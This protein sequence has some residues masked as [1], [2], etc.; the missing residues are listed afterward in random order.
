M[1]TDKRTFLIALKPLRKGT[2]FSLSLLL[3]LFEDFILLCAQVCHSRVTF[4]TISI[5]YAQNAFA[6]IQLKRL[7]RWCGV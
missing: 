2:I 3:C 1:A 4:F 7:V 6:H 5:L